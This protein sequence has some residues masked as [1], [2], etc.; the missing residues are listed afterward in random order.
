VNIVHWKVLCL[1]IFSSLFVPNFIFNLQNDP[2]IPKHL[3]SARSNYLVP[4]SH[5]WKLQQCNSATSNFSSPGEL[6][7]LKHCPETPS[8]ELHSLKAQRTAWIQQM[9]IINNGYSKKS[10]IM[11][12]YQKMKNLSHEWRYNIEWFL[13]V[14]RMHT[15]HNLNFLM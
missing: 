2:C 5:Q 6:R 14:F 12:E 3:S 13:D 7:P 1:H 9:G 11:R 8:Y 10:E 4:S 15:V